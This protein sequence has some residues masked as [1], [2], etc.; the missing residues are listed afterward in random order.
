MEDR[1]QPKKKKAYEPPTVTR[2]HV[3]PVRDLLQT[4]GKGDS[5]CAI[6]FGSTF[7]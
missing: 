6:Q 2:V 3:D 5:Q 1:V 7:T 4:C